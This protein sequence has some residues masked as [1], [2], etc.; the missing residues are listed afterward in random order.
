MKCAVSMFV[1]KSKAISEFSD[2]LSDLPKQFDQ[3]GWAVSGI[4]GPIKGTRGGGVNQE[5]RRLWQ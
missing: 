1:L 3:S 4:T 5:F 2:N